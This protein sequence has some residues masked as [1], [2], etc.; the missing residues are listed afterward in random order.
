MELQSGISGFRDANDPPLPERDL[1]VFLSH[2]HSVARMA[3]GRFVEI[4]KGDASSFAMAVLEI[5]DS[6]VAILLHRHFSV[7]GL[8]VP[9]EKGDTS[10]LKFIDCDRIA[11]SLKLIG[12]DYELLSRAELERAIHEDD[13]RH[14]SPAEM[15]ELRYWRPARVGDIVFNFWD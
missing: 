15:K 1:S 4:I 2:C 12:S 14:L 5:S 8:A 7:I 11:D 10:P 9:P 3:G 6:P 13:L